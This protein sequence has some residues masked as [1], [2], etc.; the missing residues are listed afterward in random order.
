[1]A[2]FLI[3]QTIHNKLPITHS[4][5]LSHFALCWSVRFDWLTCEKDLQFDCVS[6]VDSHA[7][8]QFGDERHRSIGSGGGGV[9]GTRSV[10]VRRGVISGTHQTTKRTKRTQK[11][12]GVNSYVNC[13][14]PA[15]DDD[16]RD[17]NYRWVGV[18]LRNSIALG[19]KSE[20]D[21]EN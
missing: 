6:L 5:T 16:K 12:S 19:K 7:T 2:A 21:D 9:T 17:P 18:G 14:I 1:M 15:I 8:G 11:V 3:T 13:F 10:H 4:L 20:M